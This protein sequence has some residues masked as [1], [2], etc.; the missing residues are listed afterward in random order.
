MGRWY[1][2]TGPLGSAK[3]VPWRTRVDQ[4]DCCPGASLATGASRSAGRDGQ[5]VDA[6]RGAD[7]R[8][9]SAA[10][11]KNVRP[12]DAGGGITWRMGF[13]PGG[14][15][16]AWPDRSPSRTWLASGLSWS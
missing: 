6:A 7:N 13:D 3:I 2:A 14:L 4:N 9:V 11:S 16:P 1:V 15:E 8:A 5:V 12:P 10:W